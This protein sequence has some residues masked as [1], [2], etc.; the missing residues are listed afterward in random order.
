M[1]DRGFYIIIMAA[2][3][4]GTL[5]GYVELDPIKALVWSAVVNGVISVP[6]MAA[7]MWIGQSEKLMGKYTITNRH[8]FFGC[9]ATLVMA[10]A[11]LVMFATSI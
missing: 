9:A 7:L 4:I 5:L 3:G 6:L 10:V 8:R 2:T 11:V 1:E